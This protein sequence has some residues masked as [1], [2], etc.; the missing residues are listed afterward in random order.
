MFFFRLFFFEIFFFVCSYHIFKMAK[1]KDEE[2][3]FSHRSKTYTLKRQKREK[4]QEKGL[5]SIFRYPTDTFLNITGDF[6]S[7]G[8]VEIPEFYP[9]QEIQSITLSKLSNF[10][11]LEGRDF[12]YLTSQ[13]FF[14]YMEYH[15]PN[16]VYSFVKNIYIYKRNPDLELV[17]TLSCRDLETYRSLEDDTIL[18]HGLDYLFSVNP[19]TLL[20]LDT[21]FENDA[22]DQEESDWTTP[23]HCLY[24]LSL[25]HLSLHAPQWHRVSLSK[26]DLTGLLMI[27]FQQV[28]RETEELTLIRDYSLDFV[29]YAFTNLRD[30]YLYLKKAL[31]SSSHPYSPINHVL[32]STKPGSP[33]SYSLF[34]MTKRMINQELLTMFFPS[35]SFIQQELD[36]ETSYSQSVDQVQKHIEKIRDRHLFI[37]FVEYKTDPPSILM[38]YKSISCSNYHQV[39]LMQDDV[40]CVTGISSTDRPKAHFYK[41]STLSVS[42]L[43]FRFLVTHLVKVSFHSKLKVYSLFVDARYLV[44]FYWPKDLTKYLSLRTTKDLYFY[45]SVYDTHCSVTPLKKQILFFDTEKRNLRNLRTTRL[46]VISHSSYL[47]DMST[48]RIIQCQNL[49]LMYLESKRIEPALNYLLIMDLSTGTL[50][51]LHRETPDPKKSSVT[52]QSE[53]FMLSLKSDTLLCL[54]NDALLCLSLSKVNVS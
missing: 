29:Y 14:I 52:V 28:Y 50:L 20:F 33:P 54:C 17:Y 11:T 32:Y 30:L 18:S 41:V 2:K 1:R 43:D 19:D 44:V 47:T 26:K 36:P 37:F 3:E 7:D 16:L 6:L 53:D 4:I 24:V 23:F 12:R 51:F 31:A 49:L 9:S 25:T 22:M 15:D 46:S 8:K 10:Q 45:L 34:V 40:F 39:Q 38:N 13:G 35:H 21:H 42:D 27:Y 48:T 5:E